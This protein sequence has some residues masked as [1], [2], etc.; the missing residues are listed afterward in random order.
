MAGK[1]PA[2]VQEAT[3][4][5]KLGLRL[6][7][8]LPTEEN[9]LIAAG[10]RCVLGVRDRMMSAIE[11]GRKLVWQHLLMTPEIFRALDIE[12]F[13]ADSYSP[14]MAGLRKEGPAEFIDVAENAGVPIDTCS[15]LKGEVGA[16]LAGQMPTPSLF[17]T[18]SHPCDAMVAGLQMVQNLINVP[19]FCLDAPVWNDDRAIDYYAQQM[20]EMVTFLEEHTGQKL[21]HDRL[22]EVVEESNRAMELRLAVNELKRAVPCPMSSLFSWLAF[23]V[24]FASAGSPECTDFF[25]QLLDYMEQRAKAGTGAVPEEKVRVIW[26]GPPLFFGDV[27]GWM[28]RQWGAVMVA[29]LWGYE[30]YHYIDT[31]S[32]DSM[33]RG[34]A[35]KLL[36]QI[37]AR[38]FRGPF[39]YY[40]NDFLRIYEE[41]KGDCLIFPGSIACKS[42]QGTI[43]I[44]KDA[45]REMGIPMLVV[46]LDLFDERVTPEDAIKAQIEQ[47]FTTTVLQ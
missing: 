6:V 39:E 3:D 44:L 35:Q 11:E 19:T 14:Q 18:Q 15:I 2:W 38:E 17:V 34:L 26:G 4:R 46:G 47:F 25:R 30:G 42:L 40:L 36:D 8:A 31:S 16:I 41:F 12:T 37:M 28:E 20:K 9:R 45:C 29:I 22:R 21:D 24:Y 32:Y 5:A 7:E 33:M 23:Q 27:G 1:A 13:N 43:G 10:L